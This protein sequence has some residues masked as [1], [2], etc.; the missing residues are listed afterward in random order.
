MTARYLCAKNGHPFPATGDIQPTID[1]R[2]AF[3]RCALCHPPKPDKPGP[4]VQLVRAD[5]ADS[6]AAQ[7]LARKA[8]R[9]RELIGNGRP[10]G[11]QSAEAAAAA[12]AAQRSAWDAEAAAR[13]A[14]RG[15]PVPDDT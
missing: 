3:G 14:D 12:A 15:R 2:F 9:R 10:R 7:I 1:P 13:R 4:W 8:A 11:R 6:A 5:Y